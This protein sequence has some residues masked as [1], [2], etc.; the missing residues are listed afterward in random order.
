MPHR[1]RG[2]CPRTVPRRCR[3]DHD[4]AIVDGHLTHLITLEPQARLTRGLDLLEHTLANNDP[5][6]PAEE[7]NSGEDGG[8]VGRLDIGETKVLGEGG[9]EAV[10]A[11]DLLPLSVAGDSGIL[12]G[13]VS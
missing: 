6:D 13:N 12:G 2:L 7:S 5:G 8:E 9:D 4:R 3:V 1:E 10:T 11:A